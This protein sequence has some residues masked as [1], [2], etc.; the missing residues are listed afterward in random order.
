MR[1]DVARAG[2]ARREFAAGAR[3]AAPKV[4][5][6]VAETVVPLAP[7]V[8]KIAEPIAFRP[9]IPR[10][11]DQLGLR[12]NRI[13]GERLEQRRLLVEAPVA[14]SDRDAEIEAESVETAERHPALERRKRH[15]DDRRAIER[16][17]IAAAGVVDV[18][19][20]IVGQ[21]PEVGGVV[22]AAERQSRPELVALAV[23]VEHDVEQDFEAGGVQRVGRGAHFGPAARSETRVGRAEHDRIVAPGVRQ[24]ERREVALVDEDVDWHDLDRRDAEALEMLDHRRMG[25]AGEGSARLRRKILAQ[26]G[27]AAQVDLVND[28]VRPRDAQTPRLARR[29]RE[30]D[31]LGRVGAAV[32]AE[33]EHRMMELERPIESEGVGVGEQLR[34]IEAVAAQRLERPFGAQ[35]IASAGAD[36]GERSAMDSV[37]AARQ[38]QTLDLRLARRVVEAEID[39]RGVRRINRDLRAFSG[40]GDAE[41]RFDGGNIVHH[42]DRARAR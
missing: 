15:G 3:F 11:G 17:A 8:G 39:R 4:A 33:G 27:Q 25:E 19:A 12:Q 20:R 38:A 21:K 34:R 22:E 36:A 9:E 2:D 5:H 40:E 24:A 10:F 23:V 6:G 30:R 28:R 18:A 1:E 42:S 13:G 14:S 35:A 37:V 31:R 26:M 29:R 7:A 41:R 32:L 16:Q